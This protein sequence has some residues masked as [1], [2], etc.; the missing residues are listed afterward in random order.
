LQ[1]QNDAMIDDIAALETQVQ[2]FEQR[3]HQLSEGL[4]ASEVQ[5]AALRK[6]DAL[7]AEKLKMKNRQIDALAH[8]HRKLRDE[9]DALWR[10]RSFRLTAPLRALGR[11]VR[12]RGDG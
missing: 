4:A 12:G 10:S 7:K 8:D 3:A 1:K 6:A 9:I 11:L 5:L 2:Q